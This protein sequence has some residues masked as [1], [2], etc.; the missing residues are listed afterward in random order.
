VGG[1][2]VGAAGFVGLYVSDIRYDDGYVEEDGPGVA[3]LPLIVGPVLG[4]VVGYELSASEPGAKRKAE[5]NTVN[6][7]AMPSKD[8]GMELAVYGRF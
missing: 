7:A 6:V 3:L 1:T 4:A 5:T 2:A 8:G